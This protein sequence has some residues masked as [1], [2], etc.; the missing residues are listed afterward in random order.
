M[1]DTEFMAALN[2][3]NYLLDKVNFLLMSVEESHKKKQE[4][5]V[6]ANHKT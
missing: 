6:N 2:R 1:N 5:G 4:Y 3:A